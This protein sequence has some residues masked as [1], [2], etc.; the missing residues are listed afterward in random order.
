M[1]TAD[2]NHSNVKKLNEDDILEI[3]LEYFQENEFKDFP[4]SRGLLI[5]EPGKD[6]RFICIFGK[7]DNSIIKNCDLSELDKTFDYNGDHSF[8]DYHPQ[9]KFNTDF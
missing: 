6:L 7:E 8:L 9:F 1:V 2:N 3:L 5:G 4:N